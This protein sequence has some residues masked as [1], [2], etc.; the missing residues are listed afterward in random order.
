MK[1]TDSKV[2]I[3]I[4]R[5]IATGNFENIKIEAGLEGTIKEEEEASDTLEQMSDMV[6]EIV[7]RKSKE[8]KKQ[9]KPKKEY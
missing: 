7:L 5:T 1:N 2:I 4:T 9:V 3:N 6:W 8:Y